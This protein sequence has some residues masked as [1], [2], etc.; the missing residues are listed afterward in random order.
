MMLLFQKSNKSCQLVTGTKDSYRNITLAQLQKNCETH[1]KS[2]KVK[3]AM[4]YSWT[5][6]KYFVQQLLMFSCWKGTV[7]L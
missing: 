3:N 2:S 6:V 5:T 4:S 1:Q 7:N